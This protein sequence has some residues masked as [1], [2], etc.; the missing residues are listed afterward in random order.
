[1]YLYL[2]IPLKSS[3][4][5]LL[6]SKNNNERDSLFTFSFIFFLCSRFFFDD[7]RKW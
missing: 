2:Y 4:L 1:M 3:D 7:H 6:S 5:F